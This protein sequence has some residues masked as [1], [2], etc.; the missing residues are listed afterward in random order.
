MFVLELMARGMK[1]MFW[2]VALIVSI[3]FLFLSLIVKAFSCDNYR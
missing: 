3:P 2:I 1:A